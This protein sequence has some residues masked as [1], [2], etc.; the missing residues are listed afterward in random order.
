MTINE[1]KKISGLSIRT[2]H[3]YDEIGLLKPN[4]VDNNGYRIYD[5]KSLERLQDILLLR[6]LEFP[7]KEI[8]K[9]LD[10]PNFDREKALD[11]QIELLKL[12]KEHINNLIDHALKIKEDKKLMDFKSYDKSKI[13][14]YKALAKEAWGNTESY[15]EYEEKSKNKTIMDEQRQAEKLM[16]IFYEF[17][18]MKNLNPKDDIV[19]K[20]VKKLK[21]YITENYYKCTNE[22]LKGLG[23]MYVAGGEM[24]ENIDVAGG[25]GTAEFVNKAIEYFC[26]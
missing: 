15:K 22:I 9:I 25:K 24:T 26:K 12:K 19:Q 23:N 1:V 4:S 8:K 18:E 10:N 16:D 5:E 7:L 13:E 17:G 2:L 6:E 21:D 14:N 20:Q 3:Y 11:N